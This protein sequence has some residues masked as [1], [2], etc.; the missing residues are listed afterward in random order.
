[1]GIRIYQVWLIFFFRHLATELISSNSDS[2]DISIKIFETL[3]L[4]IANCFIRHN[5][6]AD[7]C[8]LL[9]ELGMLDSIVDLSD[10]HNYQKISNYLSSC[11]PFETSPDDQSLYKAV[12]K[13]CLKQGDYIS[14]FY[15]ALKIDDFDLDRELYPLLSDSYYAIFIL[16]LSKTK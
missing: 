13:V 14:A 8:D 3:A 9:Y 1:M 2:S 15:A 4:N 16:V 10:S 5:A 12:Y 6:E 7:A 11:A